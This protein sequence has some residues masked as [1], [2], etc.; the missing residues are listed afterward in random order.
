MSNMEVLYEI[1]SLNAAGID[2]SNVQ[3]YLNLESFFEM[4][5]ACDGTN[6]IHSL[7]FMGWARFVYGT[8]LVD[9]P[10]EFDMIK[11]IAHEEDEAYQLIKH[12]RPYLRQDYLVSI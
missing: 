11:R 12:K 1:K 5:K 8:D 6:T 3:E 10:N 7:H 9:Y 4:A 2:W